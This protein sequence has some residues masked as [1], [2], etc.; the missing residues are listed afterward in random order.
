VQAVK[1][2]LQLIKSARQLQADTV[3]QNIKPLEHNTVT[4]QTLTNYDLITTN[5]D[6]VE[7]KGNKK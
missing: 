7:K 1:N 5:E 3:K 2:I 4:E 6:S